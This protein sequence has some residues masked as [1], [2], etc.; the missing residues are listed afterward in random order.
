MPIRTNIVVDGFSPTMEE[1]QWIRDHGW[2][3]HYDNHR[4]GI[5][6]NRR[7]DRSKEGFIPNSKIHEIREIRKRTMGKEWAYQL[8]E[9]MRK[10]IQEY[11]FEATERYKYAKEKHD[12]ERYFREKDSMA[13][14]LQKELVRT[15]TGAELKRDL[16]LIIG[17]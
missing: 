9:T 2:E 5:W 4:D 8:E 17:V 12:A 16:L 10:Q 7:G 3:W 14:E 15:G 6:F 13:K 1:E 11:T